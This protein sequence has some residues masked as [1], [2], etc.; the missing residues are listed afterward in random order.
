MTELEKLDFD[1]VERAVQTLADALA[2]D[3]LN[4]LERDGV[5]QRFE[6]SFELSWK[7][8]RKILLALGRTDVSASPKPVLRDAAEEGFIDDVGRWFGFLEAR[9]LSTHIYS[10][11]EAD[12]VLEAARAFLPEAQAFLQKLHTV[13]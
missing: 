2:R 13:R 11:E 10:R 8:M 5:I 3:S 1:H 4:D 6:Y 12:R 9:N 7:M